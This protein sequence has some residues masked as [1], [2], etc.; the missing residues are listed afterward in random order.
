MSI[1][2]NKCLKEARLEIEENQ[3]L[4]GADCGI[5]VC[6]HSDKEGGNQ[7]LAEIP[8][9]GLGRRRQKGRSYQAGSATLQGP[10]CKQ[11]E[12]FLA[13]SYSGYSDK[14]VNEAKLAHNIG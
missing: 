9:Q 2:N 7:T 8:N 14:D 4:K 6:I 3:S 5:G 12:S 11:F 10:Q 1:L 13:F